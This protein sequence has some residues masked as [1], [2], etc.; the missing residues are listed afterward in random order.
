M[1]YVQALNEAELLL[2][3][4]PKNEEIVATLEKLVGTLTRRATKAKTTPRKLTE[5]EQAAKEERAKFATAVLSRMEEE[6]NR[7]WTVGE[8]AP[9][10]SVKPQKISVTLTALRKDGKVTRS[11]GKNRTVY[12]QF[13][14][15]KTET[16]VETE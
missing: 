8:L 16:E 3:T 2:S 6:P 13:G 4:D 10:F 11:E 15:P 9:I 7:L 12:F 1:T 5:A 14:P